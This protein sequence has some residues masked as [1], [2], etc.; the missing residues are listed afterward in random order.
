MTQRFGK[1]N[2]KTVEQLIID[3]PAYIIYLYEK[4]GDTAPI[5]TVEQYGAAIESLSQQDYT[6]EEN[7][8]GIFVDTS[9]DY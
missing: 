3:D 9:E 6:Y 2:D 1:Y 4:Y 7:D 5:I 8:F